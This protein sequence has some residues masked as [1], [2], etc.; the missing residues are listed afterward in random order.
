[1]ESGGIVLRI[2]NLDTRWSWAVSFMNRP[3]Y[4]RYPLDRRLVRTQSRSV[5]GCTIV[6]G[7][8]WS[9]TTGQWLRNTSVE[10]HLHV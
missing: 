2:L 9:K 5:R 6:C 8:A 7:L 4:P 1:L 3:L 10:D